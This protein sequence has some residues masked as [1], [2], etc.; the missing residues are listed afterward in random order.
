MQ[1]LLTAECPAEQ[2]T[3]W[4]YY[5]QHTNLVNHLHLTFSDYDHNFSGYESHQAKYNAQKM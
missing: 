5:N 3:E 2:T 4:C 1:S